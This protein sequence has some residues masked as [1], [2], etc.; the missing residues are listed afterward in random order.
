MDLLNDSILKTIFNYI[1][2]RHLEKPSIVTNLENIDDAI[3]NDMKTI[4]GD[5]VNSKNIAINRMLSSDLTIFNDYAYRYYIFEFMYSYLQ[6]EENIIEDMF[7]QSMFKSPILDQ[8]TR[9]YTQF[10][11]QEVNIIIKFMEYIIKE[12]DRHIGD[13]KTYNQLK[14][15]EQEEIIAPFKH[16][17]VEIRQAILFWQRHPSLH[18]A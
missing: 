11:Y 18:N 4:N 1:N 6:N 9:R 16:F 5:I 12:I 3:E 7:I 2:S 13:R 15:W 14:I 17:E 8:S 10:N